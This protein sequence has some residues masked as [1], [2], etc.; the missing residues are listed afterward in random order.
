MSFANALT[1]AP[2]AYDPEA[3]ADVWEKLSLPGELKALITGTAGS[4]PFLKGLMEREAAWLEEA[5]THSADNAFATL[6]ADARALEPRDLKDSL[7]TTRR[8]AAL[9]IALADLGGVWPLERVT[10]ALTEFADLAVERAFGAAVATELDRGRIEGADPDRPMAGLVALA[11]GKMGAGEL[12]YSSD[13]DLIVLFDETAIEPDAFDMA[14]PGF[15]RA[16]RNAVALLSEVTSGGFVFRTDLR[17]RPDPSVTPVALSMSAAERYYEGLGRTWERAAFIKARAAAGD[18]AAGEAF[19]ESL[20]PFVWR[21]HLDYAALRDAHDMRLKIQAHKRIPGLP[22]YQ[23]RD[24]KLG[25]G[26]IREIEFFTQTR[27]LIAGGRDPELRVRGTVEGLAVLAQQG[28]IG[29]G[30]RDTLSADYRALREAEHRIQMIA[31]QQTHQVPVTEENFARMAAL[32]DMEPSELGSEIETRGARVEAIAEGFFAPSTP[33]AAITTTL[34]IPEGWANYPALRSPRAVEIFDRVRPELVARLTEASEPEKALA[35][36]DKFLSGL[37]AGVQLFSLF[38]ANPQLIDLIVDICDTA[39]DLADYLG[40][41]AGVFDAVIAGGF[42]ADWPGTDAL[43]DDLNEALVQV[44]DYE[45]RLNTLRIRQKEWHFRVGVH[46]LRGLVTAEEAGQ[47]YADV[48]EAV[49]R[50]LWPVVVEDFVRRFGPPPGRGAALLAMGSLG[51]RRLHS[52]S[53]IDLIVIYDA[54]LDAESEGPKPL[55]VPTYF[56]RLTKALMTALTAPMADGRLYEVDMRLRPSG[57]QGP[58]ATPFAAFGT[59]Q[60]EEAWVWEHLALTRARAVVGDET[61]RADIEAVRVDVLTTPKPET[62]AL[63]SVREMRA[64]LAEAMPGGG[65]F[66]ARQGPGRLQDIELLAQTAAYLADGIPRTRLGDQLLMLPKLGLEEAAVSVISDAAA[67]FWSVRAA[68]L[69]AGLSVT[70]DP[71]DV[72]GGLAR[73]LFRETGAETPEALTQAMAE[74]AEKVAEIVDMVFGEEDGTETT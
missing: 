13:I 41:N 31:D 1:R 22:A 54:P 61:L 7:R 12:N 25:P 70:S 2:R 47:Q 58:V 62:D 20:A 9:L 34:T 53:D 65:A 55:A 43:T 44:D 39:P 52:G 38:E 51:A 71:A 11:M 57:R 30:D 21:K 72:T 5:M 48:A 6:M 19:L 17:L 28:W 37:P 36:F 4:S 50:A 23:G 10:G 15:V 42:F 73:F 24:L 67:L 74:Q 33:K 59:Y 49:L 56:A 18:I 60:R 16:T 45:A 40:R 14:R 63:K 3:G 29:E 32:M 66:D 64:R 68:R 8:R 35:H 26:G 27:Q 69:L 46:H